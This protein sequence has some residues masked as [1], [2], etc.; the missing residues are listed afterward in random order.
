MND[1]TIDNNLSSVLLD[2]SSVDSPDALT[3]DRLDLDVIT[4]KATE[5]F[6]TDILDMPGET[7]GAEEENFGDF[8]IADASFMGVNDY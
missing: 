5:N 3:K 4:R 8:G 2:S 1:R 7:F 6:E